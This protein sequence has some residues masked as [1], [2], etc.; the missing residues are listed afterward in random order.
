MKVAGLGLERVP[1]LLFLTH[2]IL[3]GTGGDRETEMIA[4]VG[5][6]IGTRGIEIAISAFG[7]DDESGAV[8]VHINW[9]YR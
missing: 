6:T 9:Q 2:A 4:D 8:L 5:D 3:E 7:L 1:I